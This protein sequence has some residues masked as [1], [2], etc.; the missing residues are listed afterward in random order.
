MVEGNIAIF[1]DHITPM[2]KQ[3]MNPEICQFGGWERNLRFANETA[4]VI[5]TLDVGPRI[6]S[7]RLTDGANVL[8]VIPEELGRSGEKE[9]MLR[10]GHRIW[11]AP[12]VKVITNTLDN[13]PV[14]TRTE[15]DGSVV[16][17]DKVETPIRVAK[18]LRVKMCPSSSRV[19]VGHLLTNTGPTPLP[20]ASWGITALAGGGTSVVPLPALGSS[21]IDFQPNHGFVVWPYARLNDP[22]LQFGNHS[23][24]LQHSPSARPFKIGFTGD[25]PWAAYFVKE[26][27]FLKT[28]SYDAAA[29]YTDK[30]SSLE[31]YTDASLLEIETLSPLQTL[32]PGESV[33][34]TEYWH[35]F[36]M[37]LRPQTEEATTEII[38]SLLKQIPA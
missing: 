18:E 24:S 26:C 36:P 29:T 13:G 11:I 34:H 15:P 7:Y 5:V 22:R 2:D 23:V 35:L 8:K 10:G 17:L 21:S 31:I 19:E 3:P 9:W 37:P 28:F 4:E 32:Q 20:I 12:E 16:F 1:N 14:D 25:F 27:L 30:G 38:T 33:A 6:M